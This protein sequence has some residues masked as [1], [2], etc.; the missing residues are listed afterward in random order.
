M[1]PAAMRIDRSLEGA[2]IQLLENIVARPGMYWGD[3]ENHFHSFIAFQVGTRFDREPEKFWG[4]ALGRL[5]PGH[6]DHFV[7]EY[8]GRE[9]P[10]GGY[11]WSTFIEKNSSSD[12]EALDLL[13]VLRRLYSESRFPELDE[14]SIREVKR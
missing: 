10:Y 14:Q 5:I 7:T 11:G 1:K 2:S 13:L 9:F 3:S 12:K 8:Y 4:T 6:F